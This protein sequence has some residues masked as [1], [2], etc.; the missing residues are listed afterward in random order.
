MYYEEPYR[1]KKRTSKG[2]SRRRKRSFGGVLLEL[3]LR[4]IALLLALALLGLGAL[5]A[6]P[7]SLFAV[8]PEGVE[9]SL[10]D[11]LPEDRINV[12]LLGLDALRESRQRSDSVVIASVGYGKL[13]LTSVLRDTMVAI[14]G[15]GNG[16]LNAAY[17]HGG[18]ELVMRTL[19][20]AFD[21]NLMHY[22]AVDFASLVSVVDA[23]GGVEVD[24]T[25]AEAQLINQTMDKDRSKFEPLGYTAP[26][27]TQSGER[28]HL[29]GV[30]ALYFAR[31]RKLD[32]DFS[33]TRRQRALLS[34]ML[35]KIRSGLWNP[36]MLVRLGRAL[37]NACVTNLSPLQLISLGLKAL[38]AGAP[39]QLRLPVDN[40]FTDD[41]SSLRID[42]RQRNIDAFRMFAYD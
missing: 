30:Q 10:T 5:Y 20:E 32:S 11:G 41:G 2:R 17:A 18:A 26:A 28:T 12:L 8:E 35:G 16:K 31:I 42:D 34:A 7:V 29:N 13:K 39:E 24:V 22:V 14:P 6:L 25:E 27:L 23:I 3:L 38:A 4:L 19:N 37:A 15:Y 21:L 9:L 36:A 40:T 33:R 1:E